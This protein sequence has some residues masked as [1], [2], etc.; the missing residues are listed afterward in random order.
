VEAWL[1]I[2]VDTDILIDV[3]HG[4]TVAIKKLEEFEISN[5][6]LAICVITEMELLAGCRNKR[7]LLDA[8]DFFNSLPSS[9][10]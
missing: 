9:A 4:V 8:Q 5:K 3:A 1:M 2:L 7:E 6:N 10:W